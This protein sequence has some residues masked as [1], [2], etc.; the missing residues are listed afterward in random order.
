MLAAGG[1]LMLAACGST[2]K[3]ASGNATAAAQD[4][5]SFVY[6]RQLDKLY[7]ARGLA[8]TKR[9]VTMKWPS[10]PKGSL[11]I[12]VT[13][14]GSGPP[15]L[16]LHGGS[17]TSA[18]WLPLMTRLPGYRLITPDL[19]GCGLSDPFLYDGVDMHAF[20]ATFVAAVM[21]GV[22][23]KRASIVG[24]WLGGYWAMCAAIDRPASAERVILAGGP[25]GGTEFPVMS[26]EDIQARMRETRQPGRPGFVRTMANTQ[27]MP[28]DLLSLLDTALQLPG[29]EETW[30]SVWRSTATNKMTFALRPEMPK[31]TAP[32]LL[33]W[34]D[35][36]RVDPPGGGTARA[37]LA[38]L[39]DARA[40][41][42]PDAGHLVWI[43]KP[44]ECARQIVQFLG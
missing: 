24:N 9:D 36:D 21:D 15:I 41:V 32:V 28:D 12:R 27:R 18:H 7:E 35:Q 39:P 37:M 23:V 1:G 25:A 5:S 2:P 40:S 8:V 43:D 17:G 13:E 29:A 19:P 26:A 16:L 14:T 42:V 30:R 31:L 3:G 11:R 34:G 6:S 10:A 4:A 22:Q 33:L 20:G 44:D 38:A